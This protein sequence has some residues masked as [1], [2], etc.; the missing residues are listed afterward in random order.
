[1]LNLVVR[2]ETAR[3][4]KVNSVYYTNYCEIRSALKMTSN[5]EVWWTPGEQL[6]YWNQLQFLADKILIRAVRDLLFLCVR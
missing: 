6:Y 2:K 1:M 4:Q 3:L 5:S